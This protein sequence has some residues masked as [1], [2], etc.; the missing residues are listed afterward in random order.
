MCKLCD[1]PLQ[2]KN[3][4]Q[5]VLLFFP[6]LLRAPDVGEGIADLETQPQLGNHVDALDAAG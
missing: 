2:I 1:T 6:F 4:L 3:S 5:K